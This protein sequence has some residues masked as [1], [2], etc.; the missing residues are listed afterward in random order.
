MISRPALIAAVMVL[1]LLAGATY[2][3][4][5]RGMVILIDLAN[6]GIAAFCL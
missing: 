4:A 2:L 1:P 6:T 3:W 5:D